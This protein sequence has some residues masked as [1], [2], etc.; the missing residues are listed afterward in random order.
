MLVRLFGCATWQVLLWLSCCVGW[1]LRSLVGLFFS[2]QKTA[3]EMR[4]SD[5]SSDVCSSDLAGE[6]GAFGAELAGI[7]ARPTHERQ[8]LREAKGFEAI[9]PPPGDL[10]RVE[11]ERRVVRE[12]RGV[13]CR[14]VPF[15]GQPLRSEEHT[16]ELQSLM[17]I[18]YAVFCFKKKK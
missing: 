5:W 9:E 15:G 11:H 3:Y 2:K 8:G 1:C 4:I 12:L 13:E 16:S 14:A 17:R 7:A 10:M 18:S 6:H